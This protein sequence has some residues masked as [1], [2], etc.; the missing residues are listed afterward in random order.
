MST[1]RRGHGRHRRRAGRRGGRRAARSAAASAGT[2][3]AAPNF[4][5]L[6]HRPLGQ[7]RARDAGREA[8]VVLDPRRRARPARRW[9]RRRARRSQA[10]GGAVDG[11]GEPGRAGADD[12]EVA[13]RLGAVGAPAARPPASSALLGLR[14][15]VPRQI[16]TGVS[17]GVTSSCAQQR[18]GVRVLLQVDPAGAAAGCGRRTRAAGGCPARTGN[19]RCGSR[20]RDRSATRR[21]Q[22]RPQ[23]QVAERR[24]LSDDA[25]AAASAGTTSTS[26]RLAHDGGEEHRPAR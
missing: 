26:A 23:D 22:V 6:H 12:D 14:S 9:R 21:T 16:T 5:R 24:V 25:R 15:T 10:L 4:S 19:R 13:H 3:S 11:G 1:A 8:E 20:R 17:A 7:L 2:L 18:L